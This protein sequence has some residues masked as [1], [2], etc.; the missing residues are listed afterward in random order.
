MYEEKN[1][2]NLYDY[3]KL[4]AGNI[5]CHSFFGEEVTNLK[6]NNQF[7]T[8]ELQSLIVSLFEASFDNPYTILRN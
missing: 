5:I 2:A 4:T 8:L 1:R 6:V 3:L 7:I